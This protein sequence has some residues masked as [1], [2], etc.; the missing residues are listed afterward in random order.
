MTSLHDTEGD[1]RLRRSWL[2][3][4]LV[5]ARDVM[6]VGA[7]ADRAH[8]GWRLVRRPRRDGLLREAHRRNRESRS[9]VA[10][11][12]KWTCFPCCSSERARADHLPNGS[13]CHALM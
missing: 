12:L 4:K 3:Q 13:M 5:C 6:C 11:S 2:W 8:C 10:S 1:Q 7:L 9:P